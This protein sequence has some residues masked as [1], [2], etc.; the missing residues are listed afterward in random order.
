MSKHCLT[1]FGGFE[2]STARNGIKEV[3]LRTCFLASIS[4]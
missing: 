1:V 4:A 2:G 3:A